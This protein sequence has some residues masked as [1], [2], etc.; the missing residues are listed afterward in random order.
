MRPPLPSASLPSLPLPYFPFP[1]LIFPSPPG[2]ARGENF[3]AK[4]TITD[5]QSL[6]KAGEEPQQDH[7]G[8][9]THRRSNQDDESEG[10]T[11]KLTRARKGVLISEPK[12]PDTDRQDSNH[13]LD[14]NRD[15]ESK[16]FELQGSISSGGSDVK[17][18]ARQRWIWA[19]GRVCQLIRR[20][21]RKSFEIMS[22]RAT[23]RYE[24][25]LFLEPRT[26]P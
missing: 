9:R 21:K 4:T 16:E 19:F 6:E 13:I 14:A 10:S 26:C 25:P 2:A 5:P 7:I 20:R 1:C 22:Q 12:T 18:V 24:T 11:G 3:D 23:D 15:D 8:S 17:Y